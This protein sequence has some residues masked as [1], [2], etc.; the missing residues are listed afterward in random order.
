MAAIPCL[1]VHM[2]WNMRTHTHTRKDDS[3]YS[4]LQE[5]ARMGGISF[6]SVWCQITRLVGFSSFKELFT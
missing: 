6:L 4:D 5:C 1:E 3:E 2:F